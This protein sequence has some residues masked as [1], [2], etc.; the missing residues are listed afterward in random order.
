MRARDVDQIVQVLK[1]EITSLPSGARFQTLRELMRRFGVSQ[2]LV[3]QAM[4]ILQRDGLIESHV[5]RGTF[6]KGNARPRSV[7]WVCGTDLFHGDISPYYTHQ[8]RYAKAKCA[9]RGWSLD[10]LWLSNN[11]PEDAADYCTS[12]VLDRHVGFMFVGCTATHRLMAYVM[13]NESVPSVRL[14]FWPP[15]ARQVC[16]DYPQTIE[17]GISAL[18][19]KGHQDITLVCPEEVQK[20]LDVIRETAARLGVC[21]QMAHYPLASWSAAYQTEGYRLMKELIETDRLASGIFIMDDIV[22]QGATRMLLAECTPDRRRDLDIVVGSA[23]QSMIPLGLPVTYVVHDIEDTVEHAVAILADQIE[24]RTGQPDT[25]CSP[26]A[27]VA[28]VPETAATIGLGAAAAAT[29][30]ASGEYTIKSDAG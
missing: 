19:S 16:D 20:N 13:R 30:S 6:V 26:M 12:A 7:L 15:H 28:D 4:L 25:Y 9:E 27:L 24:G 5:G 1:S 23:R 18:K 29:V 21:V 3:S 2:L 10:H 14:T 22:A 8:L 17:L 11:R